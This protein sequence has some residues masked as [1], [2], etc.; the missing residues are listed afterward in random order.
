[1]S[2]AVGL[3]IP[4]VVGGFDY[5]EMARQLRDAHPDLRHVFVA[6]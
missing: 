6:R 5:R 3:V 4:D 2:G 1:M